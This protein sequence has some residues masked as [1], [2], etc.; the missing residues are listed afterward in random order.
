M[1]EKNNFVYGVAYGKLYLA[2]EYA[3]LENY[4]KA[5]LTSVPKKIMAI[6]EPSK[7][8][9]IFDTVHKDEVTLNDNNKNFTLIQKFIIFIQKYLNSSKTFSLTIYNELHGEGKKYGLGSSGA[10]LVA[11]AKAILNFEKINFDNITI[12]K[13][14]SLFNITHNLGG[15]MGD[16]A[17]SL[18]DGLTYYKKFN[19]S[20]VEKLI[21]A[22]KSTQDIVNTDWDG[23]IIKSIVPNIDIDIFAKWTGEVV[24]TKEHVKLWHQHKNNFVT[25]YSN[26]VNTSNL[27]TERLIH[28]LENNDAEKFLNTI[29]CLRS[30]LLFLESFSKIPMETLAMKDYIKKYS[31][32]KQSGSGSGDI[33][34]GFN[35]SKGNFNL[36]LNLEKL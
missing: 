26:F 23:L 12:F 7:K 30:N 2:G 22:K 29:R 19:N 6:I 16:I 20:F 34:L 24:D 3:I 5:L 10:V 35:K 27:L 32:G 13:I 25:E 28:S 4:S 21:S 18:N 15:S 9:T 33:V 1:E 14:V 8:I 31:A 17:A 36:H 11:I